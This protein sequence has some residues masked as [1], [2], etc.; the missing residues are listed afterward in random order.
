MKLD[1]VVYFAEGELEDVMEEQRSK[2]YALYPGGR[3]EQWGTANALMHIDNAYMEW[4]FVVDEKK[5]REAESLQPLVAQLLHDRQYGPGW[6][7]VCFSVD[8]IEH[9]KE[10][11]DNKGYQTTAVIPAYRRT[12]NGELIRWKMLFVEQEPS[13]E[14][15]YPFFIEWEEREEERWKR[16]K[17]QGMLTTQDLAKR[18][19][20]CVFHVNDPL[21]VTGEW[22]VLLS[23]KVGDHDNIRIGDVELRFIEKEAVRERLAEVRVG[24]N[25]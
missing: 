6:A 9:F 18:V 21:H 24:L 22:A 19:T 1:H 2:G 7:T 14:L 4:L 16:L 23:Q 8:D 11:A 10:D 17:E 15:P 3:H 13:D 5:A 12:G 25:G 20:E